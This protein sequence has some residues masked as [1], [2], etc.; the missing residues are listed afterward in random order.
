MLP[1]GLNIDDKHKA[2][3][4]PPEIYGQMLQDRCFLT[5][6]P[7]K[8]DR[9]QHLSRDVGQSE[10]SKKFRL[11]F[12]IDKPSTIISILDDDFNTVQT[13]KTEQ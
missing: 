7:L 11:Y 10:Y 2:H 6:R 12:S 5:L 4:T 1:L 3:I 13:L 8:S 9:I